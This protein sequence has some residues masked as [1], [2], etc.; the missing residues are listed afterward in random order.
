MTAFSSHRD[1]TR[2]WAWPR[3]TCS[4]PLIRMEK[5]SN[6]QR[7]RAAT[8]SKRTTRRHGDTEFARRKSGIRKGK[9]NPK[10]RATEQD[11]EQTGVGTYC[12]GKEIEENRFQSRRP[13]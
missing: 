12:G 4:A 3:P 13:R 2:G 1:R 10:S 6:P 7:G 5:G 8:K 11:G 9:T